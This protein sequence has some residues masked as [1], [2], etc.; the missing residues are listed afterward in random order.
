MKKKWKTSRYLRYRYSFSRY[1]DSFKCKV[2]YDEMRRERKSDEEVRS[3]RKDGCYGA[4]RRRKKK[5]DG[6]DR[7]VVDATSL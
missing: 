1:I 2:L 7:V 3:E 6:S 4:R 5:A